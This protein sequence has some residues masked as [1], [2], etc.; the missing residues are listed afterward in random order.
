MRFF[1]TITALKKPVILPFNYQYPLSAC[2]YKILAEADSAYATFL[3][4]TGYRLQGLKSFKLF[5]FSDISIPF[6]ANADRMMCT[7]NEASLTVCFHLPQP[8]ETFIKGLFMNREIEIADKKSRAVFTISSVQALPELFPQAKD[9]E[10][11]EVV[12]RPASPM[13]CAVKNEKNY[14]DFLSPDDPRFIPAFIHHW[15]EK[16]KAAYAVEEVTTP[17]IATIQ[18]MKQPPKPRK[19]T[20]KEGTPQQ[21]EI[22]G[23]VNFKI[24]VI[25]P[26]QYIQLLLN[27]GD[28]VY[29]SLGMGCVE[30]EEGLD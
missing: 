23:F 27:V 19:I 3:H 10:L 1:I 16:I 14:Y 21:T 30:V 15:K 12:L 13:V 26:K 17:L 20:I 5:T 4:D 2:I 24:K 6:K 29:T 11:L 25:A 8:S 18:Q 28:G 7:G 22:R 9:D